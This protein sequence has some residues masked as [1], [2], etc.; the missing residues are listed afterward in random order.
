MALKAKISKAAFEKLKPELQEEYSEK[1]GE[2]HLDVDGIEDAGNALKARDAEKELKKLALAENAKL[3]AQLAE[4]EDKKAREAGDIEALEASYKQKLA[5]A[6]K[7][8]ADIDTKWKAQIRK[9]MIAEATNSLAADVFVN[10]KLGAPHIQS[11]FDVVFPDDGEPT[12]RI[13]DANGKPTAHSVADL[14]KEVLSNPDFS[15]IL[16]GTSASGGGASL[17]G[18]PGASVSALTPPVGKKLS[19]LSMAQAIEVDKQRKAAKGIAS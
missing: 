7:K 1:D 17:N 14:K 10:A 19:E 15:P 18:A 12:L 13:L 6:E 16:K 4:R 11:R 3:K 5:D 9:S 8:S 2:Y